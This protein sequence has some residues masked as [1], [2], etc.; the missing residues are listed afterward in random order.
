MKKYAL[1][2]RGVAGTCRAAAVNTMNKR[3]EEEYYLLL[4]AHCNH[5]KSCNGAKNC[6]CVF[7]FWYTTVKLIQYILFSS[8]NVNYILALCEMF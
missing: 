2:L 6:S 8:H 4:C 3:G 7:F 1:L 5:N